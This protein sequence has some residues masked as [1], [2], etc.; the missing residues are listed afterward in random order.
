VSLFDK[1]FVA[2]LLTTLFAGTAFAFMLLYASSYALIALYFISIVYLNCWELPR[3]RMMGPLNAYIF[4][5][6]YLLSL[7]T[8]SD[9]SRLWLITLFGLVFAH[10][11]AA[12]LTGR[13]IGRHPL[14]PSISPRKTW[15]GFI[16]GY[17]VTALLV[18][19]GA[20][21]MHFWPIPAAWALAIGVPL[22]ATAGDLA[23]SFLKRRAGL[24]DTGSLL[25]GH[26]GL[27]DRLDSILAVTPFV[28]FL[29]ILS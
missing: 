10:D 17:V 3:F 1:E 25:P 22:L 24:K 27:L 13:L 23:V 8:W 7:L 2:R 21:F 12:Y 18:F 4:T 29:S 9:T 5:C 16:G 6:F 26:G 19:V 15:E 14:C 28:Y 11:T 20:N